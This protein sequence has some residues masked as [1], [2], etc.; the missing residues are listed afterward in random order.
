M[1]TISTNGQRPAIQSVRGPLQTWLLQHTGFG[2]AQTA[3]TNMEYWGRNPDP[4][5][6][7]IGAI[8]VLDSDRRSLRPGGTIQVEID[9]SRQSVARKAIQN[10]PFKIVREN[11]PPLQ[12]EPTRRRTGITPV[13]HIWDF[14]NYATQSGD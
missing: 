7:R 6:V 11:C 4:Q 5:L 9:M 12:Q 10:S 8:R 2:D 13:E 14:T 3:L 1:S